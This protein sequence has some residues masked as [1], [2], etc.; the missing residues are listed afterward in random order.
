M[1]WIN[2]DSVTA[3]GWS[4]ASNAI[5]GDTSTSASK[6]IILG[7]SWGPWLTAHLSSTADCTQ[8][9]I[10]ASRS[11]I[12]VISMQIEVYYNSQWN[13]VYSDNFTSGAYTTQSLG[14]TY[15]VTDIRVRFYTALVLAT[16]Y[17]H[18]MQFNKPT[19]YSK[20]IGAATVTPASVLDATSI[21]LN[22]VGQAT[23][24]PVAK[25]SRF[26]TYYVSGAIVTP[27]GV[28]RKQVIKRVGLATV[29]PIG[30]VVQKLISNVVVGSATVIPV[31]II[32]VMLSIK[33]TVGNAVVNPI[34]LLIVNKTWMDKVGGAILNPISTITKV[35]SKYVGGTILTPV[36]SLKEGEDPPIP[37][38][39]LRLIVNKYFKSLKDF[40]HY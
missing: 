21:F 13:Q 16:A 32:R 24:T 1:A 27:G 35:V 29:N 23:I 15:S 12:Q 11:S 34:G 8:V 19:T 5:D 22:T 40:L 17:V 20:S 2:P 37:P 30:V 31:G 25:L 38:S 39:F 26:I 18:V 7:L 28:L 14:G 3:N 6:T 10:Y 33:L 4:N 36:G 9:R